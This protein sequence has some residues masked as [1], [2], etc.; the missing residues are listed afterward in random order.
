[1]NLAKKKSLAQ[2]VLGAGKKRIMFVQSRLDEIKEALTKQDIR[3]LKKEGA[4]VIKEKKGRKRN[5]KRK[6]KKGP[7]KIKKTLNTRKK[8]YVRT[9]RKLRKYVAEMK[10][11]KMLNSGE[12]KDIGKKIRNRQFRSQAHL[13]E[14]IKEL[15][16]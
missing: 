2:K 7:G 10:R 15:K 8:D 12:V 11:K 9:T 3:D 6:N 16:K 13:K 4:I 5:I 1:M 14:Y